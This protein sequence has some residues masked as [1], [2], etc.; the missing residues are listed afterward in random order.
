[1]NKMKSRLIDYAKNVYSQFGEDG[2]IEKIFSIIKPAN[3]LC[4]E[5]G[6]WDGEYLSNTANLWKNKNWNAVLIE[7][8]EER[9][10]SV[11]QNSRVLPI[12]AKIG[13]DNQK[14]SIDFIL[15]KHNILEQVDFMSIDIDGDDYWI[16]EQL[17]Y[18]PNVICIEYNPTIPFWIDCVQEPGQIFGASLAALNRLAKLK[19]YFLAAVTDSNLFFIRND[20]KHLFK[21]FDLDVANIACYTHYISMITTYDGKYLQVGNPPYGMKE[22]MSEK[23]ESMIMFVE[24]HE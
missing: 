14:N 21:K 18:H 3:K 1:M 9:I 7:A 12:C 23:D 8:D 19:G 15:R 20:Y 10:K 5:F 13:Y 22:K 24:T 17:V 16:F 11:E 4:V 6:A 2:I